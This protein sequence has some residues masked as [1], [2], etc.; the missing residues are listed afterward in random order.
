MFKC[1][2]KLDKD[3]RN[4]G[5]KFCIVL[6]FC[7]TIVNEMHWKR[8]LK[9]ANQRRGHHHT[10]VRC[11]WKFKFNPGKAE[12]QTTDEFERETVYV[13]RSLM[14]VFFVSLFVSL[15]QDFPSYWG[16]RGLGVKAGQYILVLNLDNSAWFVVKGNSTLPCG[17][18]TYANLEAYVQTLCSLYCFKQLLLSTDGIL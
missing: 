17:M 8:A 14:F 16:E 9:Q 13:V 4:L 15:L 11:I 2:E 10:W 6:R 5:L 12:W 7:Q 18:W 3:I 1:T